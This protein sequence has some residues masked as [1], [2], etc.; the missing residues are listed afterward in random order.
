MSSYAEQMGRPKGFPNNEQ[1]DRLVGKDSV[2]VVFYRADEQMG[3]VTAID[4]IQV[5]D[6]A[7]K[8]LALPGRLGV[9]MLWVATEES[10]TLWDFSPNTF[11]SVIGDQ[12]NKMLETLTLNCDPEAEDFGEATDKVRGGVVF[13]FREPGLRMG[14]AQLGALESFIE[15]RVKSIKAVLAS[16]GLDAAKKEYAN[17]GIASLGRSLPV[18]ETPANLFTFLFIGPKTFKIK[19]KEYVR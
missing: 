12:P 5:A 1:L 4:T 11:S 9:G 16:E 14:N 2:L 15:E 7:W 17:M 6:T 13:K 10:T 3:M 8:S 18:S 19:F